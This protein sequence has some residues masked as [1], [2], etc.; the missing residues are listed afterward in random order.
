MPPLSSYTPF[1]SLLFFQSLATCETRPANFVAISE[2]LNSNPFV[3]QD[4]TYDSSR[5]SPQALEELYTTLITEGLDSLG[6]TSEN[7][8]T[9]PKKRK[10]AAP[11]LQD[12][13]AHST[14]IPEL[15]PRL[16]AAYKER[17]TR[18]IKLEEQRY[19][20]IKEEIIKLENLPEE[21]SP[22]AQ[23]EAEVSQHVAVQ[24]KKLDDAY[25]RDESSQPIATGHSRASLPSAKPPKIQQPFNQQPP[26]VM[27]SAQINGAAK[28]EQSTSPQII[29]EQGYS[30]QPARNGYQQIHPK[31]DQIPKL[32]PAP[33]AAKSVHVTIPPYQRAAQFPN[34]SFSSGTSPPLPSVSISQQPLK[35]T[36]TPVTSSPVVSQQAPQAAVP[37]ASTP[38][39]HQ[40]VWYPHPTPQQAGYASFPPYTNA[41]HTNNHIPGGQFPPMPPNPYGHVP[42]SGS[43]QSPYSAPATQNHFGTNQ[44]KASPSQTVHPARPDVRPAGSVKVEIPSFSKSLPQ[45]RPISRTPWKM[46][47]P[48][49]IPQRPSSP[50]PPRPEDISPISDKAPSPGFQLSPDLR[51]ART[52]LNQ[53][54]REQGGTHVLENHLA[55]NTRSRRTTPSR[56]RG[57]LSPSA[58]RSTRSRSR[59]YSVTSRDDDSDATA[60]QTRIKKEVP[61]TPA[62]FSDE[63]ESKSASKRKDISSGFVTDDGQLSTGHATQYVRCSRN[64][65]RTCGPIMND[66]ATHKYASIF[67]KPLTDRDAPGYRNLIYRPQDIKSIKSAIHQ[68]NKAVIAA[69]EAGEIESPGTGS[70][71]G[72]TPPRTNGLVLRKTAD[73]V[74]PKAIVNSSQLEK[75]LIRMF[76]NAVMFNPTPDQ[77]FGPSFPMRTDARS[78]EPTQQS[79]PEEGGI[80]ADTLE[81]YDDI[82]KAISTWRAAERA[83]GDFASASL[84][85]LRRG[86]TGDVNIDSTTDEAKGA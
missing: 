27:T 37:Q 52:E 12:V 84:L 32:Q 49:I 79:E 51:K 75:E 71:L 65:G 81:M 78:R 13:K 56:N 46:P 39:N 80:I 20:E 31:T 69:T 45:R 33:A 82:E 70:G 6:D 19:R 8:A 72:A 83:A 53:S 85:S 57:R 17:V 9:N 74:P 3:R 26:S 42:P 86:S 21:S 58:A 29:I 60:I 62:G 61:S 18:E 67:A 22:P 36:R 16:Y 76:A 11:S 24:E 55:V 77:T 2:L 1:E 7:Q 54:P 14:I 48:I 40:H 28:T 4:V 30:N 35:P 50:V 10:V 64:F 63:I 66:V 38:A 59:G 15:V 5:L 44:G 25:G 73:I 43:F 41:P 34:P 68:G 47:D 23:M